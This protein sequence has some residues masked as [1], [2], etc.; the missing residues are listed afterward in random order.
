MGE[1]P[2]ARRDDNFKQ[3]RADR[4]MGRNAQNVDHHRHPDIA[5]AAAE[6][7]TE[8]SADERDKDDDPER[9]SLHAGGRQ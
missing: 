9:D 8:E 6:K 3:I 4:K 1:S 7:T 5:R 2:V